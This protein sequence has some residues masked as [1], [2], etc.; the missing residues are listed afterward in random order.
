MK[1]LI[2]L[3]LGLL[4]SH[5]ALTH[6]QSRFSADSYLGDPEQYLGKSVTIYVDR[7]DVPAINATTDDSYRVFFVHTM[8]RDGNDY[9]PGGW[10]YVKVPKL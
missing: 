9:V 1:K 10:I 6:A 2:S 4:I 5:S 7:V 3:A 8:G